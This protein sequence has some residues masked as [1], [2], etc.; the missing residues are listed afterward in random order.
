MHGKILNLVTLPSSGL[1]GFPSETVAEVATDYSGTGRNGWMKF[2]R[3]Q[4]KLKTACCVCGS[5]IGFN[6]IVGQRIEDPRSEPTIFCL[7]KTSCIPTGRL[8][9]VGRW[10]GRFV[11][12]WLSGV[13]SADTT[14]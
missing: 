7:E 1:E 5:E 12:K 10:R 13:M 6:E 4:L 3:E 8:F 2:Q 11:F 9:G 14:N